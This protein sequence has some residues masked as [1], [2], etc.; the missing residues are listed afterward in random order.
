[1]LKFTGHHN[2]NSENKLSWGVASPR[3]TA[4][5]PNVN[6]YETSSAFELCLSLAGLSHVKLAIEGDNIIVRGEVAITEPKIKKGQDLKIIAMEIDH[7]RFCRKMTLPKNANT[8]KMTQRYE[9]GMLWVSLSKK[10][11][12]DTK[13]IAKA[14]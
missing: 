2:N 9:D 12:S 11:N 5:V 10:P 6:I 8:K 14:A 13:S 1:M 4:W 7:G 3:D